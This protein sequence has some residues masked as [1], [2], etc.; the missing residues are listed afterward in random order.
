M[1]AINI[2]KIVSSTNSINQYQYISFCLIFLKDVSLPY[3]PYFPWTKVLG[4]LACLTEGPAQPKLS[5]QLMSP[6]SLC[7]TYS[8][9]CRMS[10]LRGPIPYTFST[11]KS[12]INTLT[13]IPFLINSY[14]I[15][16]LQ[17]RVYHAKQSSHF[18]NRK[19]IFYFHCIPVKTLN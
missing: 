7:R 17:F 13:F 5:N 18:N 8:L 11:D 6:V 3:N 16:K 15:R 2:F 9:N 10:K 14:N 19:G 4:Q 1:N 12:A